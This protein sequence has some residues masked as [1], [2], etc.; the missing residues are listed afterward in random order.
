MVQLNRQHYFRFLFSAFFLLAFAMLFLPF[1]SEI[2]LAG[3]FALAMEPLMGRWKKVFHL[4]WRWLVALVLALLFFIIAF[5]ITLVFYK[6]YLYF[7]EIS[8]MGIQNTEF[9]GHLIG[10]WD[11]VVRWLIGRLSVFGFSSE[12][13]ILSNSKEWLSALGNAVVRV[14]TGTIYKIPR[15]MLSVFVY[16]AA[17]FFF[18]SESHELKKTFLRQKLLATSEAEKLIEVLQ[19][20]CFSTVITSL[21]IALVQASI[22]A[23]GALIMSVGDFTIVWVITFVCAFIPM[24]GAGPVGLVLALYQVILGNYPEAIGFIAVSA[25]AGTLDNLL[26]PYLLSTSDQDIHPVVGLLSILGGLFVFGMPGVFL[27][28]V[29]ASVAYKIIP[30]LFGTIVPNN[31]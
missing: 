16:S 25:V 15:V 4:R 9:F 26:R 23:I 8:R 12:V 11:S 1:Y 5:P 22:M 30:T 17:L 14:S 24:I 13:D 7:V 21:V 10:F 28:P 3:V 20:S 2:L 18:L 29:I 19:R 27:G 6:T 31:L